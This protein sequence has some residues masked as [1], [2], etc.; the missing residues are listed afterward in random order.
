MAIMPGGAGRRCAVAVVLASRVGFY[1]EGVVFNSLG[2]AQ[3]HPRLQPPQGF[4]GGVIVSQ[5][6]AQIYL[7]I[8]FSTKHRQP[9]LVDSVLRERT[10]AYLVG[11]CRNL[12]SPSIRVGGVEDHVHIL[13]CLSKVLSPSS[14]VRELKRESSKWIKEQSP[15]LANFYWQTGYG[16]FSLS[17]GHV[18]ALTAYIANQENHHKAETFKDEFLRLLEL[19]GSDYDPEH[20]WD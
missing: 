14:L 10:H 19:N 18:P 9:L 11:V 5:S 16:I 15:D 2:S 4:S 17:H 3:R 7:H 6:L 20:L 8:V 1:A 12:E 13:C